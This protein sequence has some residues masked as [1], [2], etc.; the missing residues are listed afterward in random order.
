MN[1]ATNMTATAEP[2][3]SYTGRARAFTY[4]ARCEE[5][6]GVWR[7]P[8]NRSGAMPKVS[9]HHGRNGRVCPASG[10]SLSPNVVLTRD[11]VAR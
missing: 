5:F 6:V 7:A 9:R 2:T 3:T 1:C 8:F 10:Q 11:T 4:C